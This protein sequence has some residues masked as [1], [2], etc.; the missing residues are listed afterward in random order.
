M[1][2]LDVELSHLRYF[3]AL[4]EELH[5]GRAAFRLNMA[6]P[7][8]T[9]QI[10]LLEAR[11]QCRLFERTSR[12]TRLTAAG[13]HLLERA[14]A[15]VAEADHALQ[16]MQRL[17]RGEEGQLTLA[18]APSLMLGPLPHIIRKFRKNYPRVDFRLSEM[19]SSAILQAVHAGAADLGLIRGMDEDAGIETHLRWKEAMAAILPDRYPLAPA[20]SIGQLRDEPFVFFP[21]HLGPSFYDE[22]IAWCR[23][24]GF[25][26]M[27]AQEARQWSTIVSLVSAGMGVS[28]GPLSVATLCPKSVRCLPLKGFQTTVRLVSRANESNAALR[29]FVEITRTGAIG[30]RR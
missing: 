25:T 7:P 16:S 3:I 22:V 4:A 15:I 14:R 23:K 26:P 29:N 13:S 19:A 24:T 2:Y 21:R 18:A 27:V 12:S 28:I 8:L 30:V 5:F 17:G 10:K 6:Q 20:I 9:R 11:L 1:S